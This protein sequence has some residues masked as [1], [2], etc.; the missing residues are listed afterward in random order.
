M[1]EAREE[2]DYL[3]QFIDN[4]LALEID[5]NQIIVDAKNQN[6]DD[7]SIIQ[8]LVPQVAQALTNLIENSKF[9]YLETQTND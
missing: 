3:Y 7:N 5:L 2:E 9:K 1:Y 8:L 4:A 6:Q